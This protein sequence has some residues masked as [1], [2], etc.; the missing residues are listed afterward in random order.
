MS[1]FFILALSLFHIPVSF[2]L[3]ISNLVPFYV[4]ILSFVFMRESITKLE[5]ILMLFG[6]FGIVLISIDKPSKQTKNQDYL[7]GIIMVFMTSIV[8]ASE[9]VLLRR[10]SLSL[11]PLI[12]PFYHFIGMGSMSI[13]Y[14]LYNTEYIPNLSS[15][16]LEQGILVFISGILG[17]GIQGLL[18]LAYTYEKAPRLQPFRYVQVMLALLSDLAIFHIQFTSLQLI[19]MIVISIS[20]LIPAFMKYYGYFDK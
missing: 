3:I 4:V 11:N 12:P 20:T 2:V 13:A 16:T 8:I 9:H 14:M 6:F 10:V 17:V 5:I 1:V 19:G 15:Y 18:S 7:K